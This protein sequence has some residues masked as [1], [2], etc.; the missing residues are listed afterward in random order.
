[1]PQ[2]HLKKA[3]WG[4]D[5]RLDKPP[6]PLQIQLSFVHPHAQ[7]QTQTEVP[8]AKSHGRCT[9]KSRGIPYAESIH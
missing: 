4:K 5:V 3:N 1:M 6:L 8:V 2:R 9:Q 7:I